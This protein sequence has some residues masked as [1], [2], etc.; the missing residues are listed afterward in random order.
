M[1]GHSSSVGGVMSFAL[2]F[3]L[4][5]SPRFILLKQVRPLEVA[6]DQWSPVSDPKRNHSC[7]GRC[8]HCLQLTLKISYPKRKAS[9]AYESN[10]T[11]LK[12]QSVNGSVMTVDVK[13]IIGECPISCASIKEYKI[14][15]NI[16][17]GF[18]IRTPLETRSTA[19]CLGATEG[20]ERVR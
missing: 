8:R 15:L 16:V 9:K 3:A 19:L 4:R 17:H 7:L 10:S 11:S 20:C 18:G 5:S 6:R 1:G 14:H 12:V 13:C 2:A